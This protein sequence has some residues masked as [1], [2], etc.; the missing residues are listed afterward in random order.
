M[1]TT[2]A[3][4]P[5]FLHLIAKEVGSRPTQVEAAA[6]LFAEGATV[7][8]VARYRKEATGGLDD[9]AARGRGQAARVLPGAGRAARRHPRRASPS[10]GSSTPSSRPAIRAAVTKT[11]LED[12]YLP[13]KPKRR[14]RAQIARERGLEP[15]A[16]AL[17][18]GASGERSPAL[19]A[20]AVRLGGEGGRRR[21]KRPRRG[22]G[23]PRRAPGRGRR[24]PRRAARGDGGRATYRV[25]V[26]TGKEAEGAVYRDYFEH[27]EPARSIPSHR[28]LA[29]LRG[30]REGFLI[31][32]LGST[33]TTE[34]ASLARRPGAV[35]L[36]T[37]PAAGRS[38]RPRADGY[39][40]LLRPSITNE[41]RSELRERAEEE[42]I[43]VF[44]ANL[45]ALL[46]AG[47]A[48]PGG[49]M[50]LDPGYRTGC[51]LALVDWHRPRGRDRR[52]L[53]GAAQGATWPRPRRRSWG[54]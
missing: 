13:Y 35:P 15:L 14:T 52:D 16:D 26:L 27:D 34:V 10:R 53:P 54:W 12:L 50:G 29:V 23:H 46:L 30:E 47:P 20:A 5:Q 18:A 45:E 37:P 8:F 48:R 25:R 1:K 51:K 41:V 49:G 9:A 3:L 19:L 24:G 28:L 36:S 42:A 44:R 17:L 4:E 21:R 22:A 32:E 39:K 33:T 7:P 2:A 11:A 38:P 31:S 6:A 40:R 43:A